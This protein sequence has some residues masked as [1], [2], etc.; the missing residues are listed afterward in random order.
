MNAAGY[1]I[2]G[3]VGLFCLGLSAVVIYDIARKR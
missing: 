2:I 1:I 3:S